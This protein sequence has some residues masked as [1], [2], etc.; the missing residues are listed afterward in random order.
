MLKSY[1]L[2]FHYFDATHIMHISRMSD[3]ADGI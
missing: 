1:I 2:L 3:L